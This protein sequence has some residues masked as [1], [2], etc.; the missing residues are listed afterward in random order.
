[1]KAVLFDMDGVLV[2][3][4]ESY[5]RAIKQTVETFLAV[6][7]S[8]ETIRQYKNRGGLNNDWDL[9]ECILL[10]HGLIIPK[11]TVIEVF[12]AFYLGNDFDGLIQMERW[13]AAHDVL[14]SIG[15]HFKTGI[16]TGR[17]REEAIYT[18]KRF[19]TGHLFQVV[20]T[21]D[22]VPPGK[23]KPD[24]LG[25]RLAL[26]ELEVSEGWYI[27]DSIDD[28]AAAVKAGLIPVGITNIPAQA[29]QLRDY[30]ASIVLPSINRLKEISH[31]LTQTNTD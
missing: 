17:P 22:D 27:G 5:R 11:E 14:S 19:G 16:V 3:V 28:M 30:G 18:L 26:R 29:R 23:G 8:F 13:L 25:I 12:Q 1:M 10:D 31:R 6:D 2:D 21:M 20:I 9:T 24:P 4:S 7:I 15:R